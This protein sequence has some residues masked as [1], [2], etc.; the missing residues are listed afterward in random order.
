MEWGFGSLVGWMDT[1][2][3]LLRMSWEE[4]EF[5]GGFIFED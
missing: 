3:G 1:L 5:D 4:R 2:A